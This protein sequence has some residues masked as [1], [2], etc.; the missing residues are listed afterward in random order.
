MFPPRAPVSGSTTE[1]IVG[2]FS[3][4]NT[5]ESKEQAGDLNQLDGIAPLGGIPQ[6]E[7]QVLHLPTEV[8]PGKESTQRQNCRVDG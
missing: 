7:S 4:L 5:G 2:L 3:A 1:Y 6:L 8:V